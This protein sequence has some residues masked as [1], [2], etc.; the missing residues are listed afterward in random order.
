MNEKPVPNSKLI[1]ENEKLKKMFNLKD[2]EDVIDEE[3]IEPTIETVVEKDETT[4]SITLTDKTPKGYLKTYKIGITATTLEDQVINS[5]DIIKETLKKDLKRNKGLK[6]NTTFK[7]LV[8]TK[9]SEDTYVRHEMYI[10]SKADVILNDIDLETFSSGS[11]IYN[12]M[13]NYFKTNNSD[14][15]FVSIINHKIN[16][17]KYLPLKGKSYIAL[18]KNFNNNNKGLCNIRNDDNK[19]FKWCHIAFLYPVNNHK[20]D[21]KSYIKHENDVDYTGIN[22]P[23]SLNQIEKIENL[24]K[25]NFNIFTIHKNMVLPLYISN[26]NYEKTCEMILLKELN[27]GDAVIKTH[28]VLKTDFSKLMYSQTNAHRKMY[29]CRR[30][31]QH[32]TTQVKLDNHIINCNKINVQKTIF[33]SKDNKIV[34]FKNYRYK[35]PAPFVVYADFEALNVPIQ[36][37]KPDEKIST[38]KLTSHNICSDAY[39]LVFCVNDKFSKT[40]KI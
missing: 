7:L 2:D 23:V 4:K 3:K 20:S 24:N 34:S 19:C 11:K 14:T 13:D 37:K 27:N 32:F 33:P 36:D 17:Y 10:S 40:I 12:E 26:N 6:V 15:K 31:L 38:E 8:E 21:V 28:Y 16:M 22:F 35:I 5:R 18:P 9:A 25:I 1:S 39:K 30:C 29:Y